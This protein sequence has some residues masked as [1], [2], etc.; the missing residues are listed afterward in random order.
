M[1]FYDYSFDSGFVEGLRMALDD[2]RNQ[3]LLDS[4]GLYCICI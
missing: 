4:S 2:I 1:V 3:I